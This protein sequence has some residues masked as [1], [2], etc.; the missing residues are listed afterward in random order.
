MHDAADGDVED[1]VA[2]GL[3]SSST[4]VAAPFAAALPAAPVEAD[5]AEASAIQNSASVGA[6][7]MMANSVAVTGCGFSPVAIAA[8]LESRAD[9]AAEAERQ[10]PAVGGGDEGKDAA[11]EEA[12]GDPGEHS[13]ADS[14]GTRGGRSSRPRA[15]AAPARRACRG[16]RPGSSCRRSLRRGSRASSAGALLVA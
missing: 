15:R 5:D 12:R 10:R 6:A 14:G 9:E 1:R 7:M 2:L 16:R 3:E 4:A 13:P 11:G 8:R